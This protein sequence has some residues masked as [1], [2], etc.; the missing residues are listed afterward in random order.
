MIIRF[1]YIISNVSKYILSYKHDS[2][3][4]QRNEFIILPT[5]YIFLS[6][7]VI[8]IKLLYC[9]YSLILEGRI[10]YYVDKSDRP[11]LRGQLHFIISHFLMIN[12]LVLSASLLYDLYTLDWILLN[13]FIF[14]YNTIWGNYCHISHQQCYTVLT[15]QRYHIYH[16][17]HGIQQM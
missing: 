2:L 3:Y 4:I 12:V 11:L 15:I 13:N 17:M 8:F 14:S 7:V 10:K 16:M 1:P 5:Y 6:T 9:S